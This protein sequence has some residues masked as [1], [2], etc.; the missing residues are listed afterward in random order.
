[1][2]VQRQAP[3][4]GGKAN[5][6][7]QVVVG[8]AVGQQGVFEHGPLPRHLTGRGDGVSKGARLTEG[9]RQAVRRGY[10][11]RTRRKQHPP[12][13]RWRSLGIRGQRRFLP[14]RL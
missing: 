2:C 8:H 7:R 12:R 5:L 1:M 4:V 6:E 9:K 10:A 13:G 3:G 14:A 11:A